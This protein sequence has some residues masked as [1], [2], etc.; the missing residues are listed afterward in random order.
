MIEIFIQLKLLEDQYESLISGV[1]DASFI[2][3]GIAEYV[4]NNIS[5]NLTMIGADF[6]KSSFGIVMPKQWLYV[7]YVD[8]YIL[9]L[10]ESQVHLIF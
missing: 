7:Q 10:R 6:H 3:I 9:S 5:C 8:V 1:I 4:T 2:D